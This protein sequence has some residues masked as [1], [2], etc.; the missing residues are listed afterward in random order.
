MWDNKLFFKSFVFQQDDN[1][2]HSIK[3]TTALLRTLRVKILDYSSM[4][5]ESVKPGMGKK[6]ILATQ[7]I[8][9]WGKIWTFSLGK[10]LIFY[11]NSKDMYVRLY[12]SNF[13]RAALN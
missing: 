9:P 10:P 8:V 1:P 4:F 7:N 6:E 13:V 2:N 11:A 12:M 5:L 3:T